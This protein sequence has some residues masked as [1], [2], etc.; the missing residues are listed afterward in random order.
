MKCIVFSLLCLLT[1]GVNAVA[2]I[3][4]N[5]DLQP[6]STSYTNVYVKHMHSDD[7][8]SVFVIWIKK[9]VKSHKHEHH[10]EVVTVMQGRGKMKLGE[11]VRKIRKGDVI[12]I[13][14]NTPHSVITSSRKPLKVISVQTPIFKGADR[15][16]IE[17]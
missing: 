4:I 6:D 15:I 12:I 3:S 9:E 17:D 8:A 7:K 2:Q 10:T 11:D 14:M 13:P 16:W 5:K 1:F